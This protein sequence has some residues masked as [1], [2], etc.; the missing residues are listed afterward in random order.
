MYNFFKIFND[1]KLSNLMALFFHSSYIKDSVNAIS[2][3]EV[4][5]LKEVV[6]LL[7]DIETYRLNLENIINLISN[8]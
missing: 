2:K 5:I 8:A 3:P 1:H 4:S 6:C 7:Y